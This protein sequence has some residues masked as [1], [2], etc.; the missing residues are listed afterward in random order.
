[1][2]REPVRSSPRSS[3]RAPADPPILQIHSLFPERGRFTATFSS[4]V[5]YLAIAEVAYGFGDRFALGV[6]G[7]VTPTYGFGLRVRGV[8][9]DWGRAKLVLGTR[10]L[11]YPA[12]HSSNGEPWVLALPTVR[13]DLAASPRVHLHLEAGAAL[14]TCT[15]SLAALFGGKHS[16]DDRGGFMGGAWSVAAEWPGRRGRRRSCSSMRCSSRVVS[17]W[18]TPAGSAG[19]PSC[20]PWEPSTCSERWRYSPESSGPSSVSFNIPRALSL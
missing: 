16:D 17:R 4:G 12:T 5:P 18:Q 14:A 13:L 11:Y 19:R 6:L 3:R 7:G 15:G 9:G 2:R 1:V 8:M 20:S 10:L